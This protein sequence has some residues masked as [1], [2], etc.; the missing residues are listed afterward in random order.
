MRSEKRFS[1]RTEGQKIFPLVRLA[2]GSRRDLKITPWTI[3]SVGAINYKV[4][5]QDIVST[6]GA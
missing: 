6:P 3:S 1:R 4:L 5:H 2:I